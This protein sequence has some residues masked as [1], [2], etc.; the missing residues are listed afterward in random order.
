MS[1]NPRASYRQAAVQGGSPVRLVI[2][3]YEQIIEDLRRAL[4]AHAR[5]EIEARTREI[6]HA[7]LIIAHLESSLDKHR[8]G[9]VALNLERFYQQ[10]RA[11]LI[12]AECK[13]SAATLEKQIS[14]LM[15]VRE[16]WCVV[17]RDQIGKAEPTA[18]APTGSSQPPAEGE[19]YSSADWNA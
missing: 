18:S 14:L 7:I 1:M 3:L 15:Q 17:E 16:A 8:G 19:P 6:K 4:A 5:K 2:L 12:D 10:I 11:C 9:Q 13:Q